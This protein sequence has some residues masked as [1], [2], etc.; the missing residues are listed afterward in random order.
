MRPW[1]EPPEA[2]KYSAPVAVKCAIALVALLL[3]A[4]CGREGDR[5]TAR[6]VVDRF[7]AAIEAGDGE[8]ACAQL[9]PN[10][11]GELESREQRSCAAAITGLE[12]QPAPVQRVDVYVLN[13]IAELASGEAAF[14]SQGDQGWRLSAV[15]CTPEAGKP[16]DRP[17]DCEVEG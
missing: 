1:A 12:L 16:A 8:Q 7:F 10:T 13:G 17:Y 9:S 5:E 11:R 6:A 4:G 3:L 2:A 15:G 14:L